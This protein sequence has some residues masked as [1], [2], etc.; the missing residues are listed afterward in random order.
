[1]FTCK[2][3]RFPDSTNHRPLLSSIL[4]MLLE[5]RGGCRGTRLRW[6]WKESADPSGVKHAG[7]Q[8]GS[9]EAADYS[10]NCQLQCLQSG[11]NR[12]RVGEVKVTVDF[13]QARP[14]LRLYQLSRM[15]FTRVTLEM[16]H[17]L[18]LSLIIHPPAQAP[19]N[20]TVLPAFNR[21]GSY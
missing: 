2:G 8:A 1:M 17:H 16:S 9:T 10:G 14:F 19:L 15:T 20:A 7:K 11:L 6:G 3:E 5:G 12:F 4:S 21:A 13:C 18:I